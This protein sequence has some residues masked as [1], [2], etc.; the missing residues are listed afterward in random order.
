[1]Q[2]NIPVHPTLGEESSSGHESEAQSPDSDKQTDLQMES[3]AQS[4]AL[5][6][7]TD[8][9]MICY[10]V[11]IQIIGNETTMITIKNGTY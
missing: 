1:M 9:Q 11:S 6:K 4:P 8:L 7:Q 5:D 10:I 2:Q 3:K